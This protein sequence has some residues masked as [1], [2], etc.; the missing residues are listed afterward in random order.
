MRFTWKKEFWKFI[1]GI[2]QTSPNMPFPFWFCFV[3]FVSCVINLIHKYN[4]M[5][6]PV[7]SSN[8]SPNWGW[9]L[10]SEMG[11]TKTS[12]TH[13]NMAKAVFRKR[14]RGHND[15]LSMPS[16]YL[17]ICDMKR[18]RRWCLLWKVEITYEILKWYIQ[19]Q[20][21]WLIECAGCF[22]QW[23]LKWGD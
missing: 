9:L 21:D 23:W 17:V 5:M 22:R 20:K 15:K 12:P 16:G 1:P 13:W 18:Q 11:F 3:S 7:D 8:K 10:V 19:L 2:L 4:Y 6:S 14:M